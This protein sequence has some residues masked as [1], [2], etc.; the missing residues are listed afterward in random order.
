VLYNVQNPPH[1]LTRMGKVAKCKQTITEFPVGPSLRATPRLHS[2]IIPIVPM[3]L[4]LAYMHA[5]MHT[6]IHACIHAYMHTC[7]HTCIH[8]YIHYINTRAFPLTGRQTNNTAS[9]SASKRSEQ[10]W[11][12]DSL[13]WQNPFPLSSIQNVRHVTKVQQTKFRVKHQRHLLI[14]TCRDRIWVVLGCAF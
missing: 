1:I 3:L 12:G 13:M 14:K 9:A 2:Q 10:H 7:M 6:C 11:N 4:K 5:C 8:T